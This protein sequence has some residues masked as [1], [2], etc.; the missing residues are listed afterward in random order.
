[1]IV[2]VTPKKNMT[3]NISLRSVNSGQKEDNRMTKIYEGNKKIQKV[4]ALSHSY[5]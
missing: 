3:S 5:R 1:M 4:P 2:L